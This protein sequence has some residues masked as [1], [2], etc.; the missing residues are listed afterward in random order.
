MLDSGNLRVPKQCQPFM[1]E[2]RPKIRGYQLSLRCPSS[3]VQEEPAQMV[4]TWSSI[5]QR[6][7]CS[8]VPGSG[9]ALF[10]M[11]KVSSDQDP[12]RVSYKVIYSRI[13]LYW[14]VTGVNHC[15]SLLRCHWRL[16]FL[17]TTLAY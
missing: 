12:G 6:S 14:N 11:A 15:E 13:L 10:A 16:F 4:A 1:G 3:K 17:K 7:R 9:S 5:P 8:H 2:I